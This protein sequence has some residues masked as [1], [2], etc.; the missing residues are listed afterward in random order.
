M[1]VSLAATIPLMLVAP[2]GAGGMFPPV[3]N[4]DSFSTLNDV[5]LTVPAPGFF[6]NDQ[7]PPGAF[8]AAILSGPSH[9]T[10][11]PAPIDPN[12]N[13]AFTYTPDDGFIGTDS[14]T[15][16]INA[17]DF[18]PGCSSGIAKVSIDVTPGV[19]ED[20]SYSALSTLP[21]R[22][23]SPGLLTND[24]YAPGQT[25]AIVQRPRN[26]GVF[27]AVPGGDF[28]YSSATGFAGTDTF[29]YCI[30]PP[31]GSPCL[32][33]TATVSIDVEPL[34]VAIDET[35]DMQP[36]GPISVPAPGV[37]ANDVN[38]PASDI[39]LFMGYPSNG[40]VQLDH[41]GSFT[42]TSN[43]GYFGND[44]FTYCITAPA[45]SICLSNTAT[46]SLV[47]NGAA[48][49]DDAYNT[50]VGEPLTVSAP[51]VLANDRVSAGTGGPIVA[52]RP[53]HGSVTLRSD[54]STTYVPDA[55][56]VGTDSFTYCLAPA[57]ASPCASNIATVRITV[58][59][60]ER[61]AGGLAFT[62]SDHSALAAVGLTAVLVGVL[63][64]FG[65]RRRSSL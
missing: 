39:A 45:V 3:A 52:S 1:V 7:L 56:F 15:Y 10:L 29:T 14:F 32:S 22:V 6:A 62:G 35:Y 37:L 48:A 27:F 31:S 25:P 2:A 33:N 8:F 64:V 42:Y 38:V 57:P 12:P 51:G 19:A 16:C 24:T 44:S 46:V 4:N 41:D 26:G 36:G 17:P 60:A 49:S 13:G 59:G 5:V 18:A 55:G 40:V 30:V 9:G 65:S 43:N 47:A 58:T 50:A 61:R 20:D 54:G 28:T 34:P 23:P 53:S 21:L 63:L 11:D